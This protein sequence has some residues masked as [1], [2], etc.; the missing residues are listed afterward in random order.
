MGR[1]KF[2]KAEIKHVIWSSLQKGMHNVTVEA[3]MYSHKCLPKD[4][5]IVK[6]NDIAILLWLK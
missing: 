3:P 6:E 5:T 4:E 1:K 2:C